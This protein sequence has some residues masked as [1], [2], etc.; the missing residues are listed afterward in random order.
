MFCKIALFSL[1]EY[2]LLSVQPQK[3]FIGRNTVLASL[4]LGIISLVMWFIWHQVVSGVA[5]CSD[6]IK[7]A[8]WNFWALSWFPMWCSDSVIK[9]FLLPFKI[10]L[11][12][13]IQGDLSTKKIFL[14]GSPA[15]KI[16]FW[17]LR[18]WKNYMKIL[19]VILER[20]A[21]LNVR[22]PIP[23]FLNSMKIKMVLW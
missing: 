1:F 7:E 23:N 3:L 8:N 9:M 11:F 4:P 18:K 10:K 19:L 20:G 17:M 5:L 2:K 12:F 16:V 22:N 6:L 21:N 13:L 14:L 15:L